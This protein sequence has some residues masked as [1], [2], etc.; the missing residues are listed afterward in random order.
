M[1]KRP[2][3]GRAKFTGEVPESVRREVKPFFSLIDRLAP[4]WCSRVWVQWEAVCEG[5]E[6]CKAETVTRYEYRY[7][8]ITLHGKWLDDDAEC[9]RETIIHETLHLYV[10]PLSGYVRHL[11]SSLSGDETMETV[12]GEQ[13]REYQESVVQDLTLLVSEIL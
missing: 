4:R 11:A 1:S 7:G 6:A 10:S 9:R 12:T 5:D 13:C 3:Q 8:A 2:E